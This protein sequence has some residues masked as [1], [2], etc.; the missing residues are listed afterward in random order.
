MSAEPLPTVV[1]TSG[2]QSAGWSIACRRIRSHHCGIWSLLWCKS[3]G[4]HKFS[5]FK[6]GVTCIRIMWCVF[7]IGEGLLCQFCGVF[8][9][10]SYLQGE[11]T[12]ITMDLSQSES[13]EK[14]CEGRNYLSLRSKVALPHVW[15]MIVYHETLPT[16][17]APKLVFIFWLRFRK[18]QF[19]SV[20]F[21]PPPPP[22]WQRVPQGELWCLDFCQP[23]QSE[24][25]H[26]PDRKQSES[27]FAWALSSG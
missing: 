9:P 17:L 23:F 5:K 25:E 13:R 12:F 6:S 21:C 20:P 11:F 2:C 19:Y 18:N 15:F 4:H 1:S 26:R 7:A 14:T 8:F 24:R 22:P 27:C 16:I 10:S 3:R